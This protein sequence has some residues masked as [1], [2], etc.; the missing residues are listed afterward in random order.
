M[1]L[2]VLQPSKSPT[3]RPLRRTNTP[4][5]PPPHT[6]S[7]KMDAATFASLFDENG[8]LISP[9]EEFE[10]WLASNPDL[11]TPVPDF[12]LENHMLPNAP[13]PSVNKLTSPL[14]SSP[15]QQDAIE[16]P[17]SLAPPTTALSQA[18]NIKASPITPPTTLPLRRFRDAHLSQAAADETPSKKT[19]QPQP[20]PSPSSEVAFWSQLTRIRD[21]QGQVATRSNAQLWKEHPSLQKQLL[22]RLDQVRSKQLEMAAQPQQSGPSRASSPGHGPPPA[23]ISYSTTPHP[24]SSSTTTPAS[25]DTHVTRPTS[26]AAPQASATTA[27]PPSRPALAPAQKD[28]AGKPLRSTCGKCSGALVLNGQND[29]VFCTKCFKKEYGAPSKPKKGSKAQQDSEVSTPV[30]QQGQQS[31]T[32]PHLVPAGLQASSK[33][34]GPSMMPPSQAAQVQTMPAAPGM[35]AI[36]FGQYATT[37]VHDSAT[38]ARNYTIHPPSQDCNKLG[39]PTDDWLLV[40]TTLFHPLCLQLL[41]AF[42]HPPSLDNDQ[43]RNAFA[44]A[45]RSTETFEGKKMLQARIMVAVQSAVALHEFGVPKIVTDKSA[46]GRG[47]TPDCTLTCH[48]R[49]LKIIEVVMEHAQIKEDLAKGKSLEELVRNPSDVLERKYN[50]KRTNNKK[51][52]AS[53]LAKRVQSFTD[54]HD[55]PPTKEERIGMEAEVTALVEGNPGR[56]A[57]SAACQDEEAPVRK[58]AG[59]RGPKRGPKRAREDDSP[60]MDEVEGGRFLPRAKVSHDQG[61]GQMIGQP[62]LQRRLQEQRDSF[63]DTPTHNSAYGPAPYSVT[64]APDQA[65]WLPSLNRHMQE[66]RAEEAATTAE[67]QASAGSFTDFPVADAYGQAPRSEA[68]DAQGPPIDQPYQGAFGDASA[69][70]CYGHGYQD[71]MQQ[72]PQTADSTG[73]DGDASGDFKYDPNAMDDVDFEEYL[74]QSAVEGASGWAFGQP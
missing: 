5:R 34:A 11:D 42:C 39:L 14:L 47:F 3:K 49:V 36:D 53:L 63:I 67:G 2:L 27:T 65:S 7:G 15:E 57:Q 18:N 69:W 25:A 68:P 40:K 37:L 72:R 66:R 60:D 21:N 50:N 56:R 30:V 20:H 73:A 45:R 9:S 43:A 46:T 71:I 6:I 16:A 74:N 58:L 70:S 23:G 31:Q 4:S 32:L 29:G 44:N 26:A 8:A 35:D 13:G 38:E 41:S 17:T 59:K 19:P 24:S 28:T 51:K 64:T 62:D 48:Q 54:E 52:I 33:S 12:S 22:Q 1:N 61:F 55:R 10:R